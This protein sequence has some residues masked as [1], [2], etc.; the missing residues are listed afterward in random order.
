L[1]ISGMMGVS[2]GSGSILNEP[3]RFPQPKVPP[4]VFQAQPDMNGS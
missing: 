1:R 3:A 4:G 2:I